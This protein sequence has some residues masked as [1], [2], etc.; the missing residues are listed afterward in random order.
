MIRLLKSPKNKKQK[1]A[2]FDK[3]TNGEL[4]LL[5]G[6]TGENPPEEEENEHKD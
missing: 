6:G 3:L 4:L 1:F 2:Q 5:K